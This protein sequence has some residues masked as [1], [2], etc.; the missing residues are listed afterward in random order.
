MG[1][2]VE[3]KWSNEDLRRIDAKGAFV[4]PDSVF[5]DWVKDSSSAQFPAARGRY[6]LF[7]AKN[8]PWAHRTEI[9]RK[10][11][12]LEDVISVTYADMP[13]TEGWAYSVGIDELQPKNG[14][15]RLHEVYTAAKAD[16]T[17]RVTVPTL[18][19][20]ERHTVVNNESSEIIRMLN[21]E[22]GQ[23]GDNAV[24]L[25][26][27]ALRKD[28]DEINAYVYERINNGAYRC[29]FAKSQEAYEQAF[30]RL[31]E[32]LDTLEK[33]L[34]TQRFLVGA[35][36][37]EADVRLY[38]TLVRFDAAYHGLFK[39]NLRRIE[40][41]P[42]LSNYLRDLYQRPGFGDTTDIAAIKAGYYSNRD[43]NPTG[44]VPVGPSQDFSRAHDRGRFA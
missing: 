44:I 36:L 3:G 24:D 30:H 41:Y 35:R 2:L 18:W 32:A 37:T 4:R 26:P 33:R 38:T 15:L 21:A 13:R 12:N 10:M 17:G 16:Y 19:D 31:F 29:G 1:Q 40:D 20:R 43:I 6:H 34:A 25:Y 11:K 22:F 5:R 9:V 39:C 8:C 23:W 42:N 14:V 27:E 28:I 7:V